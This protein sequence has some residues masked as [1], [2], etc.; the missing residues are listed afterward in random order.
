MHNYPEIPSSAPYML[1]L[2]NNEAESLTGVKAFSGT[3][4]TG[5]ALGENATGIRSALDA[6]AKRELGILR[7][8]A[9]GMKQIGR[10]VIA[11]NA[12]FLD[13]TEVVRIT[14]EEFIEVRR[15][16]L[17]GNIDLSLTISTAEA[18]NDKAEQLA[19]M[20]Q[21]MG[22]NQDP[23][24]TKI[25]QSELFRL[26]KMPDLAKRIEEYEPPPPDPILVEK[27]QLENEMMKAEITKLESEAQENL[28]NAHWDEAKSITEQAKARQLGSD[29]DMKDL[30]FVEQETGTKQERD[31]QKAG[32]QA[33]AN[34]AMKADEHQYKMRE[35]LL[36]QAAPK[37]TTKV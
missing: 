12:V 10:K 3:G 11:M 4:I 33:N 26:R 29:A 2:Q 36:K 32:A 34:R 17:A 14:E 9:N 18:D 1:G 23:G 25:I 37:T 8:L 24:M 5:A 19:F 22:P 28:A 21:T 27:A 15:D 7:R 16:D 6:T 35:E 30:D 13:E 20:L 31:L